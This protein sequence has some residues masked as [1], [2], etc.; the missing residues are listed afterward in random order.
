[1]QLYRYNKSNEPKNPQITFPT[2]PDEFYH[3]FKEAEDLP[4]PKGKF[5]VQEKY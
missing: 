1:M 4:A 5:Y 2:N 3:P